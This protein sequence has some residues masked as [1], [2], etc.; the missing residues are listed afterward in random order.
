MA[1]ICCFS[2]QSWHPAYTAV[3]YVPRKVIDWRQNLGLLSRLA[4]L[5]AQWLG[6]FGQSLAN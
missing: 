2:I 5:V 1:A 6:H 3:S 4:Y